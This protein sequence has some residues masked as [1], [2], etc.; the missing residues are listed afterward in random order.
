MAISNKEKEVVYF[1]LRP[2]FPE[3]LSN[4]Q[5]RHSRSQD[6][7]TTKA[8]SQSAMKITKPCLATTIK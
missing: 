2:S 4:R 1:A 5:A 6:P 7:N 8:P 3:A